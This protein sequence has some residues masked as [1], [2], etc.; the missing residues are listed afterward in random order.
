M[1]SGELLSGRHGEAILRSPDGEIVVVRLHN[2]R[3]IRFPALPAGLITRPTLQWLLRSAN[4]GE[5]KVEITYLAGGMNW[6]ADYNLLLNRDETALDLKGWVT[7]NNHRRS[8][9]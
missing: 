1:Y 3:D 4:A 2:V 9:I 6:T 5:Q 7:L 8:T